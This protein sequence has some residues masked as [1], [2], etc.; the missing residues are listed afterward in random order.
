ML[1]ILQHMQKYVPCVKKQ[2]D[3]E[4]PST[5]EHMAVELVDNYDILLGGDLLTSFRAREVQ[6]IMAYSDQP[7]LR[8]DCLLPVTEDWHTRLCLLEVSLININ[9]NNYNTLFPAI[10][11]MFCPLYII[12]INVYFI[13]FLFILFTPIKYRLYGNDFIIIHLLIRKGPFS[14]SAVLLI[15]LM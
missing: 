13:H 12:I 1:D 10:S 3:L 6:R 11:E 5:G 8:C 14:N 7:H 15:E 2:V 4:V 9:F